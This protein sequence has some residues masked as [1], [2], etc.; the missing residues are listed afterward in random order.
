MNLIGNGGF[1]ASPA[2]S[3]VWCSPA[4]F[5]VFK[6][7]SH[8]RKNVCNYI[9]KVMFFS[10]K[11]TPAGLHHTE[12]RAGDAPKPPFSLKI[13]EN[14]VFERRSCFSGKKNGRDAPHRRPS[15]GCTKTPTSN[16]FIENQQ[17]TSSN[18]HPV[19]HENPPTL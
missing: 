16:K 14:H 19:N 9:F 13:I 2:R 4:F 17:Q 10:E 11:K 8:L 3:S 18:H 1:G 7:T 15:W 6:N 5:F 12:D